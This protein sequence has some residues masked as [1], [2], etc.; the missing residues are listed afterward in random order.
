MFLCFREGEK[1][2]GFIY[3]WLHEEEFD[4]V[5]DFKDTKTGIKKSLDTTKVSTKFI[6]FCYDRD[7]TVV[8]HPID[9]K[10]E[11][12]KGKPWNGHQHFHV[13]YSSKAEPTQDR[14]FIDLKK[15]YVEMSAERTD[16][17]TIKIKFPKGMGRYLSKPPRELVR[18]GGGN[19][20]WEFN[21]F[22]DPYI[23]EAPGNRIRMQPKK[24]VP[25]EHEEARDIT[26]PRDEP[27]AAAAGCDPNSPSYVYSTTKG[28]EQ[29]DYLMWNIKRTGALSI[30]ELLGAM[31]KT[32]NQKKWINLFT[33]PQFN[34]LAKKAF[35]LERAMSAEKSWPDLIKENAGKYT[36]E[37]DKFYD[38]ETSLRIFKHWC[39]HQNIAQDKF[40]TELWE[41]LTGQRPK[42]NSFV[43]EGPPNAGKSYILRTLRHISH[44]FGEIHAGDTN[45]FQFSNCI[46]V[47]LIYIDE[48]RI[49]PEIAEQM[50]LVLEG[51]PTKVKVK[52]R[53]DEMLRKTP[54]IMTSNSPVWKWCTNEKK[55]FQARM[56]YY[57]LKKP[58]EWLKQCTKNLNP[59]IWTELFKEKIVEEQ[60]NKSVLDM[61]DFLD[62][63]K[64][65]QTGMNMEGLENAPKGKKRMLPR[66]SPH[67][68]KK[69][70][71]GGKVLPVHPNDCEGCQKGWG[72]QRDHACANYGVPA[73]AFDDEMEIESS[74]NPTTNVG[75]DEE[76]EE[77]EIPTTSVGPTPVEDYC[78]VVSDIEPD[79]QV[80][81]P[82]KK[83]LKL[84]KKD[85][86]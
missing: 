39:S 49:S 83:T 27:P 81:I 30:G 50:K 61:L 16:L 18:P 34:V 76:E 46:N 11:T 41:V 31:S 86:P 63:G 15:T 42:I 53:E 71:F 68:C 4:V 13:I 5:Q 33:S 43:L 80:V 47:N 62:L 51:C 77:A 48:P 7:A 64:T 66:D 44:A 78:E 56:I 54:V 79:C 10:D 21:K 55:A 19:L 82:K 73:D 8:Y 6:Q 84:K 22:I 36:E 74:Q 28:M 75:S 35:E 25:V 2:F 29:L 17:P 72:S 9:R 67:P 32:K 57:N 26:P 65:P 70:L 20:M 40:V 23:E 45:A 1:L 69:V 14:K 24:K 52:N 59:N 37:G 3:Q 38:T 85:L 58:C 12:E 60:S